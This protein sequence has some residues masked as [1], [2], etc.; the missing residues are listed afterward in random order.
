MAY[1]GGA[2][3]AAVGAVPPIPAM[4]APSMHTAGPPMAP[5]PM[6]SPGAFKAPSPAAAA[7][8]KVLVGFLVTFHN[9]PS[10]A[11]WPVHSGRL[12]LGRQG[13]SGVDVGI[14]DASASARHA[15]VIA[16][17]TTGQAFVEDD[18]SRNGTFVNEQRLGQ[19]EQRQL[20]DND[21]IRIGSTTIV[22]KLL[23]A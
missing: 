13:A 8:S 9:E 16:D 22:V 19:G 11:F 10:G 5:P 20:R 12:Q 18:G 6:V 21:R 3:P 14:G 23:V 17:P 2:A 1:G 4:A 7:G 15:S